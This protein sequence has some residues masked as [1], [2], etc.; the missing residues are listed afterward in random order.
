MKVPWTEHKTN[1]RDTADGCD[2]KRNNEHHQKWTE[3]M[4]RSHPET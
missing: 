4:A 1:G 2:R 3:E